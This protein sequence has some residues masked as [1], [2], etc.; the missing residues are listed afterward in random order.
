M[1]IRAIGFT[2]TID[3]SMS[4]AGPFYGNGATPIDDYPGNAGLDHSTTPSERRMD[5]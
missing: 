5:S 4:G 2:L 3:G 1:S